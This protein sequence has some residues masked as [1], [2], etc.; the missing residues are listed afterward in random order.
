MS[1]KNAFKCN[2]KSLQKVNK[3]RIRKT[4]IKIGARRRKNNTPEKN[5]NLSSGSLFEGSVYEN[6]FI[7]NIFD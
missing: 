3:K 5:R 1:N 6:F 7:L 2:F 4:K